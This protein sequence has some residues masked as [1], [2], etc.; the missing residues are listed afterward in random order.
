MHLTAQRVQVAATASQ[1]PLVLGGD[2]TVGIGTVAGM[3]AAASGRIGLIHSDLN[4]PR[5][6]PDGALDWMGMVHLLD[7]PDALP[8]LRQS[9]SRTPL[10]APEQVVVFGHSHAHDTPG[11][12]RLTPAAACAPCRSRR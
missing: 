9:G 2:C 12:G 8:E 4:T 6:V 3:L 10:L 1:V 7:A 5:C 11:S